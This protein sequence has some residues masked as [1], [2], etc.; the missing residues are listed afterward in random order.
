MDWF[1][2]SISRIL[3]F[4]I[5]LENCIVKEWIFLGAEEWWIKI[6]EF[7][8]MVFI[9]YIFNGGLFCHIYTIFINS[10]S[11]SLIL[12]LNFHIQ[13]FILNF[14]PIKSCPIHS[15]HH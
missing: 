8:F 9:N 11:N 3:C 5:L 10:L 12:L 14:L 7:I 4:V 2:L 15:I 6:I 1:I 13:S